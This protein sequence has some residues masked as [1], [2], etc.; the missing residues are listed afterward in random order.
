[1]RNKGVSR[2]ANAASAASTPK[3]MA[4]FSLSHRLANG[5]STA[6][7]RANRTAP[8]IAATNS[9]RN[10]R[11]TRGS[12]SKAFTRSGGAAQLVE[13][14]H[15]HLALQAAEVI[16]EQNTFQ[17]IHFVLQARRQ[18]PLD[19]FVV[20]RAV[21]VE[22]ACAAGRRAIDLSVLVGHRQAP[23]VIRILLLRRVENFGVD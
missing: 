5:S 17:V 18:H 22:P 11:W 4:C 9:T 15:D 3:V 8:I 2:H 20:L 1:M 14:L 16:D 19:P 6:G 12:A 21:E 13:F 7:K 23:L 10:R